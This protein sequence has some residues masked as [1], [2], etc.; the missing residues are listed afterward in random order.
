M[1]KGTT[2]GVAGL[3]AGAKKKTTASKSATP[4]VRIPA[5]L[6]GSLSAFTEA[7][8]EFKLA[9]SRKASAAAEMMDWAIKKRVE[10]SVA[11]GKAHS[12][13][14][15]VSDSDKVTFVTTTRFKNMKVE[16]GAAEL[17]QSAFGEDRYE[18]YF[19]I[20]PQIK[21]IDDIDQDQASLLTGLL[22]GTDER[23]MTALTEAANAEGDSKKAAK[24]LPKIAEQ[25]K[26]L[27]DAIAAADLMS[28]LEVNPLVKPTEQFSN[29]MV[30][31][32][33]IR[34]IADR[35]RDEDG[36]CQPVTFFKT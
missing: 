22:S 24:A 13:V 34:A 21:I 18:R 10:L 16:D 11:D 33:K 20:A 36:L 27:M 6:E 7:V 17:L 4:Q 23:L 28:L 8:R 9:E 5:E 26:A 31:D 19:K 30:L 29:D 2:S 3:L 12:S 32:D 15:I 25:L 14:K 1:A 35:V